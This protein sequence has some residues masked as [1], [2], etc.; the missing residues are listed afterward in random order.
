MLDKLPE[1]HKPLFQQ[2]SGLLDHISLS[3]TSVL[4]LTHVMRVQEL[5]Q[6]LKQPFKK[7]LFCPYSG[8]VPD[9]LIVPFDRVLLTEQGQLLQIPHLNAPALYRF[10]V[11]SY[12]QVR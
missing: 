8:T 2:I 12:A 9:L 1:G 10:N 4:V 6:S 5:N 11:P 7:P 3:P